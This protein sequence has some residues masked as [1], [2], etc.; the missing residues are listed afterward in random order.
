MNIIPSII[1]WILPFVILKVSIK[2][3][4][5]T[6]NLIAFQVV[7]GLFAMIL[8]EM[9]DTPERI[10]EPFHLPMR[11][12]SEWVTYPIL[13]T[14]PLA[15]L[16]GL[17]TAILKLIL[18]SINWIQSEK[19]PIWIR[20]SALVIFMFWIINLIISTVHAEI[21]PDMKSYTDSVFWIPGR[22]PW[23]Y[24]FVLPS[25]AI[26]FLRAKDENGI[27]IRPQRCI[28]FIIR[29]VEWPLK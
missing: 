3:P 21:Y 1:F 27:M 8:Y 18:N 16:L 10:P 25:E 7:V 28:E 22:Y 15:L 11:W 13:L 2:K 17:I 19:V 23:V 9:S 29:I 12:I 20:W 6:Q 24:W 4:K 26:I 14:I 5:W